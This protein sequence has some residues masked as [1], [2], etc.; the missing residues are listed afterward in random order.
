MKISKGEQK[1]GS[2]RVEDV[3][4]GEP[5]RIGTDYFLRIQCRDG[6]YAVNLQTGELDTDNE[7]CIV[8]PLPNAEFVP[9]DDYE[10]GR[11]HDH[12]AENSSQS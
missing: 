12:R 5:F 3:A 9:N 6:Y 8:V 2:I 7:G 1:S 10:E 11:F 4:Y